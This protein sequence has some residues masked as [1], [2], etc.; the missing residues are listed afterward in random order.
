VERE[1]RQLFRELDHILVLALDF[2]LGVA[3]DTFTEE[4]EKEMNIILRQ[5]RNA[6]ARI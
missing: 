6:S 4:I 5:A 3:F 1:S 2:P